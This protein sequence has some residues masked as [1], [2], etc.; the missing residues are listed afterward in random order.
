MSREVTFN[1]REVTFNCRTV[2]Y[3]FLIF[4]FVCSD[5]RLKVPEP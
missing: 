1:C 4:S 2:S 5:V 3:T